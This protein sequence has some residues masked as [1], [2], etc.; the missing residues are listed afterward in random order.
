VQR[1][2]HACKQQVFEGPLAPRFMAFSARCRLM[3]MMPRPFSQTLAL[4]VPSAGELAIAPAC[5]ARTGGTQM[6]MRRSK[7]GLHIGR[8]VLPQQV[9]LAG[10][11]GR[12]P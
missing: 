4:M 5:S 12:R 11:L 9:C 10:W 7:V 8:L 6:G 3:L 2:A 1:T